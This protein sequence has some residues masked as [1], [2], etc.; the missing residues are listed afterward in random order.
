MVAYCWANGV[1]G[2]GRKVPDG[3]LEI[4]R[5]PSKALRRWIAGVSRL[6]YDNKTLLVPGVPEAP[7]QRS[8]CTALLSFLKWLGKPRRTIPQ[9]VVV[10]GSRK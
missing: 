8:A 4:A 7:N 2:F 3:A 10:Y 9:G 6:A 1:I 5:G